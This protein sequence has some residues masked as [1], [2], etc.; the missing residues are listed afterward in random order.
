M[1]ASTSGSDTLSSPVARLINTNDLSYDF[2]D[3]GNQMRLERFGKRAVA[4][5]C[6]SAVKYQTLT[7][8][9]WDQADLRYEGSS[10]KV[11][12]WEGSLDENEEWIV[13][14]DHMR[15]G[16]KAFDMGQV[17]VFP[18]QV[19]N[20]QWLG[21]KIK[22]FNNKQHKPRTLNILNGFAYT[23]GS[24]LACCIAPNVKVC[25]S[26]LCKLTKY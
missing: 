10:G 8:M 3:C 1:T 9:M 16:L 5:S 21:R 19:D 14:F 6:V 24:T 17:G 2:F 12:K 4:R 18:E 15:F 13:Q 20:W 11:G 26:T 22:E 7:A 23:G 25:I